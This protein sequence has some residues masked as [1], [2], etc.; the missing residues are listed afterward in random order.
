MTQQF[1]ATVELIRGFLRVLHNAET[2]AKEP[3]AMVL[4]S[5]SED[6]ASW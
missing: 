6:A 3:F 1:A 4:M 2:M 5:Y